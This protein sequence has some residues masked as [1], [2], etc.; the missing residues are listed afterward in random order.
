[1]RPLE[2]LFRRPRAASGA[3]VAEPVRTPRPLDTIVTL[4]PDFPHFAKFAKDSRVSGIRLNTAMTN[5]KE[6][7]GLLDYALSTAKDMPLYFDIKGRQLRIEEIY[8]NPDRLELRL[9]HPIEVVTPTPVLFKAGADGALLNHIED[10]GRKLVF[11]G[12]P[13]YNVVVGESLHV[14]HPS[15][16]VGGPLFTDQQ[17]AYLDIAK[18]AGIREYM[19]SYTGSLAEVEELRKQVGDA[20]ITA[21]IEDAQG[22]RFVTDEY[23]RQPGLNLLAA[24]GD[25]FVEV[26]KPHDIVAATRRIVKAD[27]DAIVGSR[28]LLSVTDEAVPSCSDLFEIESLLSMGYRR[29]MFCDGLCLKQEPLDRAIAVLEATVRAYD[30]ARAPSR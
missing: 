29:F 16:K 2:M 11:R 3:A 26:S 24:R 21:K 4:W 19:L 20:P 17:L 10:G 15:L 13:Q 23:R 28:L 7:P 8:A 9:N 14:R 25:L 6:L 1:M 22:M 30:V 27:P 12:G 5:P 18:R